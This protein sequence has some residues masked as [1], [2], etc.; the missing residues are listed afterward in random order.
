MCIVCVIYEKRAIWLTKPHGVG[1]AA[2]DHDAGNDENEPH[3][4]LIP[5]FSGRFSLS[6]KKKKQIRVE[7]SRYH[8]GCRC[9]VCFERTPR[10]K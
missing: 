10:R 3:C 2:D 7:K 4:N 9:A 6:T 5:V 1:D 8:R